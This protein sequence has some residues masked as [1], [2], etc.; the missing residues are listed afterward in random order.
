MAALDAEAAEEH[1]PAP[2]W[3]PRT[4]GIKLLSV[5]QPL[6]A[7]VKNGQLV[8]DDPDVNLPEGAEVELHLVE[9]DEFDPEE[10]ERLLQ[11]IEESEEDIERGDYVDGMEFIAQLRAKREAAR[12]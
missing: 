10:R 4:E 1:E 12:R 9:D 11:A 5:M 2:R 7:H 3:P 6:K 8:L